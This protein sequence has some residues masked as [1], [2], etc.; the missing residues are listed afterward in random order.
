VGEGVGQATGHDWAAAE[1]FSCGL[2]E[3][4]VVSADEEAFGVGPDAGAV[5][6]RS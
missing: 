4:R 1:P 6:V 5:G 3:M 2:K